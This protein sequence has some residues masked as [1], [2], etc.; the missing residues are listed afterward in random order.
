M[1]A[2]LQQPTI[3]AAARAS[4]AVARYVC[5]NAAARNGAGEF[6]LKP[7]LGQHFQ[8]IL[9]APTVRLMRLP[10]LLTEIERHTSPQH[11][12]HAARVAAT[13]RMKDVGQRVNDASRIAE[14]ERAAHAALDR[15]VARP[16]TLAAAD[17]G[18][19]L[20]EYWQ[21]RRPQA[22]HEHE[23]L[24]RGDVA[25]SEVRDPRLLDEFQ[26]EM[27]LDGAPASRVP[28]RAFVFSERVVIAQPCDERG[29]VVP[30]AR[31]IKHWL[32]T[33]VT[34]INVVFLRLRDCVCFALRELQRPDVD[35]TTLS[36]AQLD[37]A[38]RDVVT[39]ANPD[40]SRRKLPWP[41][42]TVEVAFPGNI[43]IGGLSA[44]GD[45]PRQAASFTRVE[46]HFPT[47]TVAGKC[48]QTIR[49][50]ML[51]MLVRPGNNRRLATRNNATVLIKSAA[52]TLAARS[53]GASA[54]LCQSGR[55]AADAGASRHHATVATTATATSGGGGGASGRDRGA[56]HHASGARGARQG[57]GVCRLAGGQ[58]GR[59]GQVVV[60]A[61][62]SHA[63]A[64]EKPAT[65]A[66]ARCSACARCSRRRR[67]AQ[68]RPTTSVATPRAPTSRAPTPSPAPLRANSPARDSPASRKRRAMTVVGGKENTGF[69]ASIDMGMKTPMCGSPVAK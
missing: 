60:E 65:P 69:A 51:S 30:Y 28:A 38:W 34:E 58:G 37:N 10:L 42:Q 52:D 62:A 15:F 6:E 55:V 35:D 36:G 57:P 7:G 49:Q 45:Q 50:A 41:T 26:C 19:A 12:E 9:A 27:V 68:R 43:A 1:S 61:Q 4:D 66:A 16:A 14:Q 67:A 53:A 22:L 24:L 2:N 48:A 47:S 64:R 8:A 63:R 46:L 56:A 39:R 25:I 20:V 21:A 29:V 18:V 59:R 31:D 44:V 32:P 54:A 13:R 40:G 5:Y 33:Y 23:R 3:A 17:A 11:A